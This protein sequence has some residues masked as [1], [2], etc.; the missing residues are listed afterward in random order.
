MKKLFFAL[1]STLALF[2]FVLLPRNIPFVLTLNYLKT[3][4]IEIRNFYWCGN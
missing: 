4:E 2:V 3:F 1:F